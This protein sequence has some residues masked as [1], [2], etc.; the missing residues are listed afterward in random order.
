MKFLFAF[1]LA[2]SILGNAQER[3][4]VHITKHVF[5]VGYQPAFQFTDDIP[6]LGGAV[7]GLNFGYLYENNF[8]RFSDDV[9]WAWGA[10]YATLGR[11]DD[12]SAH[13]IIHNLSVPFQVDV[14]LIPG[15]NVFV[16]GGLNSFIRLDEIFTGPSDHS[17]R[18]EEASN[19]FDLIPY[20]GFLYKSDKFRWGL[21]AGRSYFPQPYGYF[22][23]YY[24]FHVGYH[25]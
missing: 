9:N 14:R 10:R 24:L 18:R 15:Y 4:E 22:N 20:L 3:Q 23:E 11:S 19:Y 25:L 12:S 16:F 2:L 17:I 5:T 21:Q 13:R 6:R 1:A 8:T 7:H